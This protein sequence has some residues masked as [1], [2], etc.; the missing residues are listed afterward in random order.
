MVK[1]ST[2]PSS[3]NDY[4]LFGVV[5]CLT[6]YTEG[7]SQSYSGSVG[8]PGS[9][10]LARGGARGFPP[11]T[12]VLHNSCHSD[13]HLSIICTLTCSVDVVTNSSSRCCLRHLFCY[14]YWRQP[15]TL[16]KTICMSKELRSRKQNIRTHTQNIPPMLLEYY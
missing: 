13:H 3:R 16:L 14:S 11:P 2:I 10:S 7:N 6:T 5:G 15:T 8:D 12:Q 9:S 4:A 1:L